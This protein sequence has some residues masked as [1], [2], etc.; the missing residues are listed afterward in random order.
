LLARQCLLHKFCRPISAVRILVAQIGQTH[1][2]SHFPGA[3]VGHEMVE[4]VENEAKELAVGCAEAANKNVIA[5][6]RVD[7]QRIDL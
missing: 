1:S 6:A 2:L 4:G 5:F 7:Q 3:D